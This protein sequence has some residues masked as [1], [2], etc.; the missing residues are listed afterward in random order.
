MLFPMICLLKGLVNVLYPYI[1]FIACYDMMMF[2]I[3]QE[4][5]EDGARNRVETERSQADSGRYLQD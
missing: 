4:T 1:F 5:T 2:C 3:E